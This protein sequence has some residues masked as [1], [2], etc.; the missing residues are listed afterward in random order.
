MTYSVDGRVQAR[1]AIG[2][3]GLGEAVAARGWDPNPGELVV[4]V[5][6][7]PPAEGGAEAILGHVTKGVI[8]LSI[9]SPICKGDIPILYVNVAF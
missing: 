8:P 7:V 6:G 5:V 2:R 9:I 1:I 4:A 3:G